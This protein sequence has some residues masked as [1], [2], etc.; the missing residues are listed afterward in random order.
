MT[1]LQTLSDRRLKR[2]QDFT[3]KCIKDSHNARF[4]P[5]IPNLELPIATRRRDQLK[6]NFCR[7][8]QY[9]KSAIPFCQGL[10][11]EYWAKLHE[12][13]GGGKRRREGRGRREGIGRMEWRGRREGRGRREEGARMSKGRGET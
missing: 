10:A 12:G 7:T 2:C 8:S 11:N 9:K 3:V 13:E 4:F 6:V 5:R 1:G